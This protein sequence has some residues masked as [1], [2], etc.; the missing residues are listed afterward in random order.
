MRQ[1]IEI[2]ALAISGQALALVGIPGQSQAAI[3]RIAA[4][5]A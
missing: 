3:C 5:N 1:K 4:K 2:G